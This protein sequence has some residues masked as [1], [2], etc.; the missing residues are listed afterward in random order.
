MWLLTVF[1]VFSFYIL[2][3]NLV[4]N[5]TY[6][7][8]LLQSLPCLSYQPSSR[9][10]SALFMQKTYYTKVISYSSRQKHYWIGCICVEGVAVV[11][12]K[13]FAAAWDLGSG[14]G[15]EAGAITTVFAVFVGSTT[16]GG[17]R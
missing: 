2:F 1:V 10:S 16:T 17:T 8:I 6:M 7:Y 3:P 14:V 12:G 9:G 13:G 4:P 15:V 11:V 5:G